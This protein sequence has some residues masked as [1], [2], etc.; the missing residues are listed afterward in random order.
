MSPILGQSAYDAR[1]EE[2]RWAIRT[3][4]L[5]TEEMREVRDLDYMLVVRMGES[6]NKTDKQKQFS[7]LLLTQFKI[8]L[9]QR[10]HEARMGQRP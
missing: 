10:E 8:Q 3:R 9:L 6:Y 1:T 7:D 4:P 5:T 2:L